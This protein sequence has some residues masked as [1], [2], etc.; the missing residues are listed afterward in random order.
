MK[1]SFEEYTADAICRAMNLP[2]FIE[3]GWTEREHPTLRVVLKPSF[4]PEVCLT[5]SRTDNG[6]SISVIAL[7]EQF[8]AKGAAAE[9]RSS[10]E[11]ISISPETFEGWLKLFNKTYVPAE[12]S[13][14]V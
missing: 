8:W 11:E 13:G 2:G 3:P 14:K 6:A 9:I 1:L 5:I 4:H 12:E 7:A 10:R